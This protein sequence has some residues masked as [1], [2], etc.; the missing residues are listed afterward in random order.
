MALYPYNK[1]KGRSSSP[2]LVFRL[3]NDGISDLYNVEIDATLIVFNPRTQVIQHFRC[4]VINNRIPVFR[5]NMPFW[6]AIET[7]EVLIKWG[8]DSLALDRCFLFNVNRKNHE[9]IRIIDRDYVRAVSE[10][11]QI[12]PGIFAISVYVQGHDIDLDQQKA[13]S[14]DFILAEIEDGFFEDI[15]PKRVSGTAIRRARP[16]FFDRAEI[17]RKFDVMYPSGE[18][19]GVIPAGS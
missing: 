12:W 8:D 7:G 14:H 9:G 13:A 4:K 15:A 6:I 2:M 17:D 1:L 11:H 16:D 18:G 5:R 10:E 3:M 19:C